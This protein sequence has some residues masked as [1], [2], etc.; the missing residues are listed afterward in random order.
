[1]SP[2]VF[3]KTP[4]PPEHPVHR[5][6]RC[7][8]GRV[9]GS[10]QVLAVCSRSPH[11][12]RVI[13]LIVCTATFRARRRPRRAPRSRPVAG[14]LRHRR[15]CTAAAPSRTGTARGC[16]GA[17]A[18]TVMPWPV[19]PMNRT[20]PSSRAS[21][22]ASSAPPGAQRRPHS[23]SSTR[24]CSWIRSTWSTSAAAPA[25]AGSRATPRPGSRSPVLVARKNCVAV[26]GHPRPE[27]QLGVAVARR[28]VD[29]VDAVAG[30]Q[31]ER[32]VGILL[33][34]RAERGGAEDDPRA[35]VPGAAERQERRSWRDYP[36]PPPARLGPMGTFRSRRRS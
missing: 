30:D 14:V 27:P 22:T 33:A 31:L 5:A 24:L 26:L 13:A 19:T 16:A 17:C 18:A 29:V 10:Y 6:C 32:R 3:R 7:R 2:T 11:G 1:M 35:L 25:S 8:P 9:S 4:G 12:A 21:T 15:S 34:D 36:P 23:S 20:S 28:G